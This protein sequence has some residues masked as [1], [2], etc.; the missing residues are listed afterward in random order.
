MHFM[1][2]NHYGH[3]KALIDVAQTV[4]NGLGGFG[5]SADVGSS[6]E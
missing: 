5:S 2:D 3:A 1:G 6:P 4:Q